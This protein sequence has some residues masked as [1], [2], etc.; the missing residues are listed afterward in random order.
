MALELSR[1][2]IHAQY[3]QF[4]QTARRLQSDRIALAR[5]RQ[6]ARHRRDPADLAVQWVELIDAEY[7]D[8]V[9][10][11]GLGFIRDGG[12]EKDLV[13]AVMYARVDGKFRSFELIS[14]LFAVE[15]MSI[16]SAIQVVSETLTATDAGRNRVRAAI[17]LV[18]ERVALD[19]ARLIVKRT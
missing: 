12:A 17:R 4:L 8:G 6:R 19:P 2:I 10:L 15:Y 11:A 18:C 7:R 9:L 1:R 3:L 5:L 16:S 14:T 13:A